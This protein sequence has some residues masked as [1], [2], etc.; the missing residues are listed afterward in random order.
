MV[1]FNAHEKIFDLNL[2]NIR[3]TEVHIYKKQFLILFIQ[4]DGKKNFI[5]TEDIGFCCQVHGLLQ[6]LSKI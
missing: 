5:L 2:N 4:K 3:N 1:I 6:K